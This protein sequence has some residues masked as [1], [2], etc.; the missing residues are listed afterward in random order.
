[1]AD[2]SK[3]EHERGNTSVPHVFFVGNMS[4][5]ETHLIQKEK[6]FLKV[7]TVPTFNTT[8]SIVLLDTE[9]C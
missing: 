3:T 8:H 9:T 2:E 6:Q 1:M 7:F 4:K 5:Y